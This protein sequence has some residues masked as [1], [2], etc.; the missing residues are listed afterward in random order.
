MKN[1]WITDTKEVTEPFLHISLR[2][3]A[4]IQKLV[5]VDDGIHFGS[6]NTK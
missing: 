5:A 2:H 6:Y 4:D 1:I 3:D